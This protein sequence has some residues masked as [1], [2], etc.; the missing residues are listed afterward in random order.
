M[1]MTT[2]A[3]VLTTM[4]AVLT[5]MAV[6][7]TINTCRSWR[8]GEEVGWNFGLPVVIKSELELVWR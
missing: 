1:I 6:V 5:M 2:M 4:A 7:L 3:V 8:H